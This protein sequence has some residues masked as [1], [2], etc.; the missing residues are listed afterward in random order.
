MS[1][2][3]P[4]GDSTALVTVWNSARA[5]VRAILP[6]STCVPATPVS[7]AVTRDRDASRL[8][9]SRSEP[10]ES[11]NVPG[12]WSTELPYTAARTPS[13]ARFRERQRPD[14]RPLGLRR[15]GRHR[16]VGPERLAL[17]VVQPFA[18]LRQRP[19]ARARCVDL[20][21]LRHAGSPT[22]DRIEIVSRTRA[23]GFSS[24][25]Y[26]NPI[27]GADTD[28]ACIP[29][30]REHNGHQHGSTP[31]RTERND[32][33]AP[34]LP[35]NRA[36]TTSGW[37]KYARTARSPATDRPSPTPLTPR[38]THAT[39][40]QSD[41]L[42][43]RCNTQNPITSGACERYA[44]RLHAM[45]GPSHANFHHSGQCVY[46]AKHDHDVDGPADDVHAALEKT[47]TR[48]RRYAR[49]NAN[50]ATS[51]KPCRARFETGGNGGPV[52][53]EELDVLLEYKTP[54]VRIANST[55]MDQHAG[56]PVIAITD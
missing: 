12:E 31:A 24:G 29:F 39:T 13:S 22:N 51:A 49:P 11:K 54:Y 20:K 21:H 56:H 5:V 6:S 16:Q 25:R 2:A 3:T 40:A 23:I 37:P 1:T 35:I 30:G 53:T 15:L 33:Q 47:A 36:E 7:V 45:R 52:T 41:H 14:P 46:S 32:V 50:A 18:D 44:A 27:Y 48:K 10:C 26:R 4:D 17:I 43:V 55:R 9:M 42:T 34:Q 28:F 19:R 8:R 38:S